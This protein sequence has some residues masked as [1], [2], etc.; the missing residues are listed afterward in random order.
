[1][2]KKPKG[3]KKKKGKLG[4][5]LAIVLPLVLIGGTVGAG[6]AGIVKI[7]GLT[8][9]KANSLYGEA[10]G[11]YGEGKDIVASVTEKDPKKS[12]EKKKPKDKPKPAPEPVVAVE[13]EPELDP[14]VGAMKLAKVWNN[15]TPSQLAPIVAEYKDPELAL[16]LSMMDSKKVAALIAILKPDRAAKLS[17]E[18]EA[19]GSVIPEES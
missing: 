17:K 16:V 12:E 6:M 19:I 7:P 1:M 13:P 10:G 9:A 11:L 14:E 4:L 18:I 8:K 3:E 2:A 5:I 15:I